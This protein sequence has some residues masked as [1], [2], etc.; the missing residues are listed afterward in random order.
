VR[1]VTATAARDGRVE[2][3]SE[4]TAEPTWHL[5]DLYD[6]QPLSVEPS[7]RVLTA[8]PLTGRLVQLVDADGRVLSNRVVVDDPPALAAALASGPARPGADQPPELAAGD[9]DTPLAQALLRLH[10]TLV[11][12]VNELTGAAPTGGVAA[13]EAGDQADD[14]LWERLEREQIARDLRSA[15]YARI[16][17]RAGLGAEPVIELLETLRARTPAEPS[18]RSLLSVLLDHRDDDADRPHDTDPARRWKTSTRIRVRARNLLR[19][20]ADA[21]TDPR[22][23][24]VHPLAPAGNFV[25]IVE[26]LAHLRLERASRPERVELTE[27]DL[28]EIWLRWLRPFVG[29]GNGDGWL[30]HLDP[31]GR[32][33]PSNRS[34]TGFRK[35]SPRSAGSTSE[36]T[37]ATAS[38]YS[39]CSRPSP[40]RHATVC[41]T[42]PTRP[43]AT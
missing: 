23:A 38:E 42:R 29:T 3:V 11:M 10:R 16:W 18:G 14:E 31:T 39:P 6:H 20:W 21:Q 36:P 40:P 13:G 4:P 24:W 33:A 43:P 2:V 8:G 28:D 19:R 25:E 32:A 9:L 22:L 27:G 35:L 37:K 17:N 30:D 7:G 12:D 5:D 1:L 34:P 15:T 26:M 41:S